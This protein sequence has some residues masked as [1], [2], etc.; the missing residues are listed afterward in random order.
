M[1]TVTF[2]ERQRDYCL[3]MNRDEKLARPAGLPPKE[4]TAKPLAG[5][6]SSIP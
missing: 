2:I 6:K 3:G 4:K 5:V 1:C